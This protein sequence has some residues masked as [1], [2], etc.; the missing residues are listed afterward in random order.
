[1]KLKKAQPSGIILPPE[2]HQRVVAFVALLIQID[3][4]VNGHK[5]KQKNKN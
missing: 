3:K 1:M 4:R 2:E 5:R